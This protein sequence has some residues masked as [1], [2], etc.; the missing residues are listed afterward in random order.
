MVEIHENDLE[1]SFGK[2]IDE[3]TNEEVEEWVGTYSKM[4][5]VII[6]ATV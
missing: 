6:E 5:A 4:H 2:S 3:I 1:E